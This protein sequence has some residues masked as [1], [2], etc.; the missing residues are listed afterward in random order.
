MAELEIDLVLEARSDDNFIVDT[1][2]SLQEFFK[3]HYDCRSRPL[4]GPDPPDD[5]LQPRRN[6]SFKR[7]EMWRSSLQ[8]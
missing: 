7:S 3:C 5:L 2:K 8:R 6:T 4:E 1:K